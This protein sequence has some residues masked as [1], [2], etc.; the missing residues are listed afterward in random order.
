MDER[1][2]DDTNHDARADD[3]QPHPA[4]RR[5]LTSLKE[6]LHLFEALG[7]LARLAGRFRT[8]LRRPRTRFESHRCLRIFACRLFD[9]REWLGGNRACLRCVLVRAVERWSGD[10]TE[11]HRGRLARV[12]QF[13]AAIGAEVCLGAIDRAAVRAWHRQL[14]A[15]YIA[16]ASARRILVT[17]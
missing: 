10:D 4:T 5:A 11:R 1:G 2:A 7:I 3:S 16:E 13:N 9:S 15:A 14:D 6:S 12:A 8:E 17:A